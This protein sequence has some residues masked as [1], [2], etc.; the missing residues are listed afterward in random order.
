MKCREIVRLIKSDMFRSGGGSIFYNCILGKNT[1]H[2]FLFWLRLCKSDISIIRLVARIQRIR[3]T[4]KH[5]IQISDT[6][7]LGAGLE[8]PHCLPI[9][10]HNNAMIGNNCTIH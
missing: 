6:C 10:V 4:R 7:V 9:V 5:G 3:F 1:S 8:I 2:R